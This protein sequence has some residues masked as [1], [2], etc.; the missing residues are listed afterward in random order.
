MLLSLGCLYRFLEDSLSPYR[1][2]SRPCCSHLGVSIDSSRI[3]YLRIGP[4]RA[5][6]A[7]TWVSLP[8]PRGFSISVS[9]PIAPMVLSLGCLYRFLEDSLSPYR[10]PSRP[11][12]SHLGV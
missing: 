7:V 1:T 5:H 3:L 6:V 2:P 12:C 11:W 8:I 4:H 9:D 10:T